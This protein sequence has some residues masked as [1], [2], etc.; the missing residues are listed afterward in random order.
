MIWASGIVQ[1]QYNADSFMYGLRMKKKIKDKKENLEQF[2]N[3]CPKI[4][5]L[6][7]SHEN[8]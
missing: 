2:L 6:F 4:H 1:Q 7:K 3:M 5:K 8:T